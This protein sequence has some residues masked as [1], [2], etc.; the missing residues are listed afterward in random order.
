[1]VMIG[2]L[3]KDVVEIILVLNFIKFIKLPYFIK[4]KLLFSRAFSLLC[5]ITIVY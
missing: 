2:R 3:I 4:S 5:N 1:M